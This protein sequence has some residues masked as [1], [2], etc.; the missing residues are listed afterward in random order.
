M[1]HAKPMKAFPFRLLLFAGR[2]SIRLGST[3]AAGFSSRHLPT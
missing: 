1:L 2:A 3:R